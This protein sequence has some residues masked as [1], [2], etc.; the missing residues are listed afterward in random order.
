MA[1]VIYH[2]GNSNLSGPG[3][4]IS[5]PSSS[6]RSNSGLNTASAVIGPGSTQG[7]SYLDKLNN[8]SEEKVMN[9][10]TGTGLDLADLVHLMD[11]YMDKYQKY[12]SDLYDSAKEWYEHMSNTAIQRQVA[13]LKAAGLNPIL[14][15][16]LGGSSV[17]NIS[18]PYMNVSPSSALGSALSSFGSLYASDLG[19]NSALA[20]TAMNNQTQKDI[21]DMITLRDLELADKTN[22][23]AIA[24]HKLDNDAKVALETA[25][26]SNEFNNL[27]KK[28]DYELDQWYKKN[29]AGNTSSIPG[30]IVNIARGI[31]DTLGTF[32]ISIINAIFG[33]KYPGL[34]TSGWF[35]SLSTFS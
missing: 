14:A 25:L 20:T 30:T 6:N 17:A 9:L 24:I 7:S 18:A 26:Q 15:S 21:T 16:S 11:K 33:T 8:N 35:S 5:V 12:N 10:Q 29:N 28:L 19:Y 3:V 27:Y 13:D 34:N 32:G 1:D 2:P 22:A 4:G 31:A 23:N